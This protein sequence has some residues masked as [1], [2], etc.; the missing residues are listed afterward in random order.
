MATR[1]M[2]ANILIVLRWC[3][4][5]FADTSR[6]PPPAARANRDQPRFNPEIHPHT[7]GSTL[8]RDIRPTRAI[9]GARWLPG[10]GVL[11]GRC[12]LLGFVVL[13]GVA[14]V[15]EDVGD[16]CGSTACGR[17]TGAGFE[18]ALL[19]V[20]ELASDLRNAAGSGVPAA[21]AHYEQGRLPDVRNLASSGTSS[22]RSY[23]SAVT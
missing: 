11:S 2:N 18:N 1:A 15:C 19:D 23:L 6:L 7:S 9:F 20:A 12:G 21:L 4:S 14:D 22:G 13:D 8:A 5:G 3:R 10:A 16:A 17:T